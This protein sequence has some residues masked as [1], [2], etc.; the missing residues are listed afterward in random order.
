MLKAAAHDLG[1]EGAHDLGGLAR[2]AAR[3]GHAHR[4]VAKVGQVQVVQQEPTVGVRVGA[5]ALGALG[6][7]LGQLGAQNARLVE[8]LLGLVAAH[9]LLKQPDVRL[10]HLRERHLMRAVRP[11]G[12]QP[13]HRLGAGP[14]LGRHQHDGRPGRALAYAL[15]AGPLLE[16]L[17]LVQRV[18]QGGGH[19][20][21]HLGR[22]VALHEVG[23]V[24]AAAQEVGQL[25]PAH[26]GEHRGVGDLVAVEVQYG[27]H[28]PVD[29]RVQE[30]VGVPSRRQ[31]AGLGLAVAYDAGHQQVRV[32]EGGSVGVRERVAQ[33]SA[34]V[35]R[36]R[37]LS[38]HMAGDAAGKRELLE[39]PL[40]AG[41]VLG[42]LGVV[43]AVGA[44]QVD[45]RH[46]GRPAVAGPAD[47][48]H[49]QVPGFDDPVEMHVDE[50]E[51]GASAPVSEQSGLD[52]LPG[53]RT[54]QQGIVSQVDLPH[55]EVVGSPP[56]GVH[57]LQGDGIKRL[58]SLEAAGRGAGVALRDDVS[59]HCSSP[60][61]ATIG[62]APPKTSL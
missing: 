10:G 1:Q 28:R 42:D 54:A 8:E 19:E 21:M 20:L 18:V 12:L 29:R 45:V 13:I 7:Q 53:E 55:R 62:S 33:L 14:A 37:R 2:R 17:D 5:H 60:S 4:E 16:S 11:L 41:L 25:L 31:R 61:S 59:A 44:L 9:P 34:L 46:H 40:H 35:D 26:A 51:A 22:V 32:V 27:Q 58:P 36:A 52:V 23:C 47:V 30:L 39:Q 3:R 56:V 50:V 43:L 6:G 38:G 24:A 48:H 15:F 49:I 57:A